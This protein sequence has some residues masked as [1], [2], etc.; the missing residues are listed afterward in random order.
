MFLVKIWKHSYRK[1][2]FVE[3]IQCEYYIIAWGVSESNEL[4]RIRSELTSTEVQ[5][6]ETKSSGWI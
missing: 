1:E 2:H 6:G 3:M 4:V 5:L